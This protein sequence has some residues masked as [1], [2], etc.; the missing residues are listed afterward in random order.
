MRKLAATYIASYLRAVYSSRTYSGGS[1]RIVALCKVY[2]TMGFYTATPVIER[3]HLR[4]S[5]WRAVWNATDFP[6][7]AFDDNNCGERLV[8]IQSVHWTLFCGSFVS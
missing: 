4:R 3:G 5:M 6:P 7:S 1:V 2:Y 8:N